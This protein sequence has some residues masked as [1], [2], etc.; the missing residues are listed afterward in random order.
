MS[1]CFYLLTL[2]SPILFLTLFLCRA[3]SFSPVASLVAFNAFSSPVYGQYLHLLKPYQNQR[4]FSGMC[5]SCSSTDQFCGSDFY[6]SISHHCLTI[7]LYIFLY[8]A[9]SNPHNQ[10]Q[11][12]SNYIYRMLVSHHHLPM[13]LLAVQHHILDKHKIH[14][15]CALK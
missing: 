6:S 1:G 3:G 5:A 2:L 4:Y 9:R 10:I 7:L 8:F 15:F 13:V 12:H 11:P 14:Y